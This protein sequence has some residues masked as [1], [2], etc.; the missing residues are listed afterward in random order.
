MILVRL[1]PMMRNGPVLA[2]FSTPPTRPDR[3]G[4]AQPS[5]QQ[6]SCK[7]QI[8]V[9]A[10]RHASPHVIPFLSG[11]VCIMVATQGTSLF[12]Y[13]CSGTLYGIRSPIKARWFSESTSCSLGSFGVSDL[14]VPT[15]VAPFDRSSG[16]RRTPTSQEAMRSWPSVRMLSPQACFE[17]FAE[18]SNAQ[19]IVSLLYRMYV[20]I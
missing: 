8:Q 12:P 13:C 14:K 4:C 11:S 16:H 20:L 1:R 5:P 9:N 10:L 2:L 18:V 17:R 6:P 19:S 3:C 15:I 7:T